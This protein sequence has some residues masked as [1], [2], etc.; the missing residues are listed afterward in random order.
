MHQKRRKF[1]RYSLMTNQIKHVAIIMDG[2]GR[3][4]NLR[5]HS[6]VWGHIRGA[7]VV[8]PIVEEAQNLKIEALTLYAFSTENWGRPL[9][10][11][12]VLFHL[13]RKFLLRERPRIIENQIRFKVI[14]DISTLPQETKKLI[15]NLE[16]ETSSFT[17]LKLTFAFGYGGRQEIVDAV[18][19]HIENNPHTPITPEILSQSLYAPELQDVDLLIRTGGDQRISN[20]LLWQMA[21]AE[22]YFTESRWPDFTAREFSK[23]IDEVETR[24]RRFGSIVAQSKLDDSVSMARKHLEMLQQ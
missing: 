9:K 8:S 17:G 16:E 4:A 12:K 6:R 21:Y 13:L 20:F 15:S 18:N 19:S 14:G 24:E 11:V 7:S 10:E 1:L 3:W 23:I 2:N 22:L 5:D